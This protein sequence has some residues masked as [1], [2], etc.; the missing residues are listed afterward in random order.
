MRIAGLFVLTLIAVS[1]G[2]GQD[3]NYSIKIALEDVAINRSAKEAVVTVTI[4]ND[5]DQTLKAEGLGQ[6]EF[7]FAR[8]LPDSGKSLYCQGTNSR[9]MARGDIPPAKIRSQ[10]EF[11]FQLD[12]V[13]LFWMDSAS[14]FISNGLTRRPSFLGIPDENIHFYAMTKLLTGYNSVATVDPNDA[15]AK[16]RNTPVYSLTYSNVIDVVLR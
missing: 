5:A 8:C 11:R 1:F 10:E 9:Y 12:L 3:R 15:S 16:K 14:G 7:Y 4:K 2:L 13:K 6:I